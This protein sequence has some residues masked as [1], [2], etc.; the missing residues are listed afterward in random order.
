MSQS[1]RYQIMRGFVHMR[2]EKRRPRG[3]SARRSWRSRTSLR[4]APIQIPKLKTRFECTAVLKFKLRTPNDFVFQKGTKQLKTFSK[5]TRV[6][7]DRERNSW[8]I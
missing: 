6:I 2:E 7:C 3:Q 5:I 8:T 1:V 4:H